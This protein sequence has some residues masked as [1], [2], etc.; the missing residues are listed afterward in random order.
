MHIECAIFERTFSVDRPI[1]IKCF[2]A[3]SSVE[4]T[5]KYSLSLQQTRRG[6]ILMSTEVTPSL[7]FPVVARSVASFSF[8]AGRS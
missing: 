5:A 3:G 2:L 6:T 7:N 4:K 8:T 1:H